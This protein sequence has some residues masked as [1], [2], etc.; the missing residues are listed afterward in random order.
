MT[1]ATVHRERLLFMRITSMVGPHAGSPL[2]IEA[3]RL[4]VGSV[5]GRT[6]NDCRIKG[7]RV[8]LSSAPGQIP[9]T[10]FGIWNSNMGFCHGRDACR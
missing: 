5:G 1:T 7:L 2:V 3:I 10:E 4:P 8:E 6:Y 9:P